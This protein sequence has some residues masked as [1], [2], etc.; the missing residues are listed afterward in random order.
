[1]ASSMSVNPRWRHSHAHEGI[2]ITVDDSRTQGTS[3]RGAQKGRAAR[4]PINAAVDGSGTG[5]GGSGRSPADRSDH[6]WG[7][8]P[9]ECLNGRS[10]RPVSSS[11]VFVLLRSVLVH[12]GPARDRFKSR[13][14]HSIPVKHVR[15]A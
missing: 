7:I 5:A 13:A 3:Q 4:L 2:F 9:T 8:E 1:M 15:L 12:A 6:L 10:R 11:A 14:L